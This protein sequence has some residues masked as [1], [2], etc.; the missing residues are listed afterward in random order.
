MINQTWE[1]FEKKINNETLTLIPVGSIEQHGLHAPLGTDLI[2]AESFAKF[3]SHVPNTIIGPT[4]PVGISEYH[5]HFSGTLWVRPETLKEYV[6]E[7]IKCFIYHGINK[8]ILVNAHG[9]NIEPLKEMA[10]YINMEEN[11]NIVVWTWF[12]SIEKKLINIYGERPPLHADEAETSLLSAIAPDLIIK[13]RL[14]ESARLAS[15]EWGKFYEGTMVSQEVKDFSK[16]GA[17]GNPSEFDI[18]VGENIFKEA[19]LNLEKLI[20]YMQSEKV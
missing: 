4:I 13:D 11:I 2:I 16:S 20:K 9:G 12:E 14:E 8:I 7:I 5:R 1:Q 15:K 17:T 19:C 18:E 6:G 3:G 10:R